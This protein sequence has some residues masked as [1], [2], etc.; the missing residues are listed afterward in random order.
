MNILK[1]IQE[2]GKMTMSITIIVC[3]IILIIAVIGLIYINF[4][5]DRGYVSKSVTIDSDPICS[6][7]TITDDNIPSIMHVSFF[8]NKKEYKIPVKVYNNCYIYTKGSRVDVTFNPSDI[9]GTI[10]IKAYD[11]KWTVNIVL[12]ILALAAILTFIYD[13][14]FIDNKTAET[15]AGGAGIASA[16]KNLF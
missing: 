12:I 9:E 15:I 4:F 14:Y 11:F 16:I 1:G 6:P 8:Y 7:S 13:Y 3:I 2:Y 5:F 10:S